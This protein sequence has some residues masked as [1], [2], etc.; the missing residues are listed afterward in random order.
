MARQLRL[1][2]TFVELADSLTD[3]FD[4]IDLLQRLSTRCVEL[5]DVSAA[6]ILLIDPHGEL[7]A[8]A[9][10]DE[11]TR[12]LELFSL[13]HD[14]GPC[15]DA[16]RSGHARV[17]IDLTDPETTE[18]WARFAVA[19]RQSGFH[20][21]HALPLRIRDRILGALNLFS[22][23]EAYLSEEDTAL[24]QAMADVAT[25]AVLQQRTLDDFQMENSQLQKALNTRIVIEQAKG[26]L[27]ER[28]YTGVD[29]AFTGLRAYARTHQLRISDLSHAVIDG[30][31]DTMLIPRPDTARRTGAASTP[32][33]LAALDRDGWPADAAT[34]AHPHRYPYQAIHRKPRARSP[35]KEQ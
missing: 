28:W 32:E 4:V 6:G 29:Q 12:M 17:N 5:L 21:T 35:K 24:A 13:Q 14:Q 11:N 18:P 25:I 9:A 1:M 26:I 23:K 8:I 15:V 22:A 19:A 10:S 27:A 2:E 16:Y 20:V 31:L 34:T 7:H 33:V 30:R 3:D